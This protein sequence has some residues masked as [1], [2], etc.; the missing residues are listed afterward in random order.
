MV[1]VVSR[2]GSLELEARIDY[3]SQPARGQLFMPWFDESLPA[4]RLMLDAF[5]PLS[6]QPDSVTCAVRVEPLHAGS[7]G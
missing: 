1:R 2:R 4:R 6:G 7:R 3:R 5:C